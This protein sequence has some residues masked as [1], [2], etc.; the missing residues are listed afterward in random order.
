MTPF[1]PTRT[2]RAL[3]LVALVGACSNPETPSDPLAGALPIPDPDVPAE[4]DVLVVAIPFD[5][6]TLY[7]VAPPF[8]QS[9]MIAE[10]VQP[11]LVRR[12]VQ[13]G[14]VS[15]SAALASTWSFSEDGTELTYH[16]RDHLTWQD[17]TPFTGNDVAFTWGLITNPVVG[18]PWIGDAP[19]VVSVTAPDDQTVVWRFDKA[20]PEDE[21]IGIT[22]RGIL[23]RHVLAG[24]APKDLAT[25][26]TPPVAS[27]SFIVETWQRRS[28]ISLAP[29]EQAPKQLQ[30]YL[31][32]VVFRVIPDYDDRID[33][34]ERGTVDMVTSLDVSDVTRLQAKNT[35]EVLRQA[36]ASMR[37]VGYDLSDPRFSDPAVRQALTIA[38]DR[39]RL[40]RDYLTEGGTVF[41]RYAIGSI[42][43][44]Q[45]AWF[46]GDVV[47]QPYDPRAA[48]AMLDGAGWKDTDNDKVRDRKG[49]S[50][51][52]SL[53]IQDGSERLTELATLLQQYWAPIGIDATI[54]PVDP[55]T[56]AKRVH[57]GDFDAY[58]WGVRA[59]PHIDPGPMW[60]TDGSQNFVGYSSATVD[61]LIARFHAT[62]D[63]TEAQGLVH[64]IQQRVHE[65]GPVTFLYWQ[66][67]VAAIDRRFRRV[68]Y[69]PFTWFHR[70]HEWYVPAQEQKY[71]GVSPDLDE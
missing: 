41:G 63:P 54:E 7:S 28:V 44:N 46:A 70:L 61:G 45:G 39:E 36:S 43:P 18:S 48:I 60:G 23:P 69:T 17:G 53:L 12:E 9:A 14:D 47:P 19:R 10:L 57:D 3:F 4:G 32:N 64:Q 37:Y 6:G 27:G 51:R 11:G 29:N 25:R 13:Q 1:D 5:P 21:L 26:E 22:A 66:D 52:F 68:Q 62:E 49:E 35:I 56:F 20:R 33:E 42:G 55:L 59:D 16:L 38:I 15:Y 67:D 2:A 40:I 31:D 58:I 34:L 71:R 65:D 24:I 8:E 30:P 50:L